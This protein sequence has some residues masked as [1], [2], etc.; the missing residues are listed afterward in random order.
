MDDKAKDF[1]SIWGISDEVIKKQNE[2]KEEILSE[3]TNEAKVADNIK[4]YVINDV[5]N[6]VAQFGFFVDN[7]DEETIDVFVS[8]DGFLSKIYN[9][10][11]NI[12]L[13]YG[14]PLGFTGMV[15]P[16]KSQILHLGPKAA[17]GGDIIISV[18]NDE[19]LQSQGMVIV[20]RDADV[21]INLLSEDIR[22]SYI[23]NVEDA[24][25]P[26]GELNEIEQAYNN[27]MIHIYSILGE[28]G[29]EVEE[30]EVYE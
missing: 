29:P 1:G 24:K 26:M 9:D 16:E 10:D 27:Y 30:E 20:I 8:K 4:G 23:E 21:D 18:S 12:I 19:L 15:D 28:S 17:N 22:D 6:I 13:G 5:G 7:Q 11:T 2:V 25:E 3:E 14:H